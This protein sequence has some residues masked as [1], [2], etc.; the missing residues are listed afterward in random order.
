MCA[1]TVTIPPDWTPTPANVNALPMPLQRYIHDIVTICDPA[2][3]V[4]ENL[5]LRGQVQQ[6]TALLAEH[7]IGDPPA[8]E[9]GEDAAPRQP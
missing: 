8:L 3:I 5:I 2:G 6:L 9:T 7:G 1:D 4:R